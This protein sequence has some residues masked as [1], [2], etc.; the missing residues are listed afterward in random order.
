MKQTLHTIL[1]IFLTLLLLSSCQK[2]ESNKDIDS[3]YRVNQIIEYKD[4]LP[5]NRTTYS[6]DNDKIRTI[7]EYNWSEEK[8]WIYSKKSEINYPLENE[9][10][11]IE[12]E[13]IDGLWVVDLEMIHFFQD[14]HRIKTETH[15]FNN[16][17]SKFLRFDVYTYENE[18]IKNRTIYYNEIDSSGIYMYSEYFWDDNKAVYGDG[19]IK[20]EQTLLHVSRDSVFYEN[21]NIF[22]FIWYNMLSNKPSS[23]IHLEYSN[24]MISN[25]A[26][27]LF[28]NNSWYEQIDRSYIYNSK[29]YLIQTN[30]VH[31]EKKIQRD[32][33]YEEGLSNLEQIYI[34]SNW[35]IWSINP[36]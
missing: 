15:S 10:E 20:D 24:N 22:K 28:S 21:Q 17:E 36:Y 16:E 32:F 35:P 3:L 13:Y 9:I 23:K 2:D 11:I 7:I 33:S 4:D 5:E 25:Y 27:Y 18:K 14:G 12:F 31:W 19:Y 29:G 26:N 34:E 8:T 30:E 6:Y 1:I